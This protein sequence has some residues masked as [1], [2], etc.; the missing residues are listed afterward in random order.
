MCVYVCMYMGVL[1]LH[2]GVY[3]YSCIYVLI[4]DMCMCTDAH[5]NIGKDWGSFVDR[6]L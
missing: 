3:V 5:V 4:I 1:F 2:I 6:D